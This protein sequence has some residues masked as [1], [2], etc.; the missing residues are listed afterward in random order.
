MVRN[1]SGATRRGSLRYISWW[2]PLGRNRWAGRNVS[3]NSANT[4]AVDHQI[5]TR[6]D[7]HDRERAAGTVFRQ[8]LGE[9]DLVGHASHHQLRR[10]E[11]GAVGL[12]KL[13]RLANV[14][15]TSRPVTDRAEDRQDPA[16]EV[17]PGQIELC[18][19]ADQQGREG[20]Q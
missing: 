13:I 15:A 7:V 1:F 2:V 14:Q 17:E 5:L 18:R 3:C 10:V 8:H 20:H 12:L 9:V 16:N 6:G 19:I 11:F 4:G